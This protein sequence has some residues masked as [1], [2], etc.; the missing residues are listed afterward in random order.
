MDEEGHDCIGGRWGSQLSSFWRTHEKI[1]AQILYI[2]GWFNA[3]IVSLSALAS[4][5]TAKLLRK[6]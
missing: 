5:T 6:H 1:L 3:P 4:T 2:A